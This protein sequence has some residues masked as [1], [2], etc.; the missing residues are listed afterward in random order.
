MELPSHNVTREFTGLVQIDQR[1]P[2]GTPL[3]KH[4]E[5]ARIT[6]LGTRFMKEDVPGS[7]V[8]PA[9]RTFEVLRQVK[10]E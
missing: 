1:L 8:V 3:F 5:L 6:L 7:Y 4:G 10:T 2:E 9:S